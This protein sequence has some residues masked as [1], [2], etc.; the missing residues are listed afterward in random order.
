MSERLRLRPCH[1]FTVTSGATLPFRIVPSLIFR[2]ALGKRALSIQHSKQLTETECALAAFVCLVLLNQSF[3]PC[4]LE[5]NCRVIV[6]SLRNL[7]KKG[8]SQSASAT[9]DSVFLG[10]FDR[11]FNNPV[12]ENSEGPPRSHSEA[13]DRALDS[14]QKQPVRPRLASRTKSSSSCRFGFS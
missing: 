1:N 5:A 3:L 2:R 10:D 7:P 6:S 11:R 14:L 9:A 12:S 4:A 13:H 8:I